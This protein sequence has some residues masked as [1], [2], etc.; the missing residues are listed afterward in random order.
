MQFRRSTAA[1]GS[2][3]SSALFDSTALE[4]TGERAAAGIPQTIGAGPQI[5]D[6]TRGDRRGRFR[7]RWR[8]FE[9]W[10]RKENAVLTE[11]LKSSSGS[12]SAQELHVNQGKMQTLR[13]NLPHGQELF[14][15]LRAD[16]EE[17]DDPEL[18]TEMEDLRYRFVLYKSKL[19]DIDLVA[20]TK[21]KTQKLS[22]SKPQKKP[23]LL[24]RVCCM[25]LP[26]WL[27]LLAL[28]L[29]A[30]MLPLAEESNSCSLSNNFARSFNVMLRYQGPPPT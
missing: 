8:E 29:L 3:H 20:D 12:L 4:D 2:H 17:L 22:R 1:Q 15:L 28:L 19:K 18:T 27:L 26:L 13:K 25:A 21:T 11:I 14:Q 6:D 7:L 30:F 16:F 5:H 24:Y 23:G 9:E 10:F